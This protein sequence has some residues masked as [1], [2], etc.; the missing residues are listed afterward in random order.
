MFYQYG[1][2]DYFQRDSSSIDR[3]VDQLLSR[4]GFS[5][6]LTFFAIEQDKLNTLDVSAFLTN[7]VLYYLM[8]QGGP[9]TY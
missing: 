9:D 8:T 3:V 4:R 5:N 1:R 2:L 6:R 7:P